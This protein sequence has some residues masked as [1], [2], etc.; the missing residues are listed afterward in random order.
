MALAV[1]GHDL[2]RS[3]CGGVLFTESE[4]SRRLVHVARMQLPTLVLALCGV[5]AA[6][7]ALMTNRHDL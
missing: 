5:A 6:L 1:Q 7:G 2:C 4:V 3:K